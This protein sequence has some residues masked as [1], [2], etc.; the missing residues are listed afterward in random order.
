ME[1][2]ALVDPVGG[3]GGMDYY[4]YGLCYGLHLNEVEVHYFTCNKTKSLIKDCAIKH[5]VFGNIWAKPKF[6]KLILLLNG[7]LQAFRYSR[8]RGINVVHYQFFDLGFYNIIAL[9]LARGFYLKNSVTLHDVDAFRSQNSKLLQKLAFSLSDKIIVHNQF[10]YDQLK[11][12][13]IDESKMALIP[14]GNYLPFVST[15]D[16]NEIGKPLHLLFFGQ[17]KEV[18]GLEILLEA[19]AKVNKNKTKVHLTIAGKPWGVD[20]NYYE[21]LITSLGLNSSTTCY[22]KYIPNDE[23]EGFFKRAD[24]IVLPYKK[25]YQSGVL[26]LAMSYGR[27]VIASNLS[28]FSEIIKDN[29]TGYLFEAQNISSLANKINSIIDNNQSIFEIRN[30]ALSLL[31]KDFDWQDIGRRTKRVYEQTIE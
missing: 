20:K 11:L 25:I 28:A 31:K 17:I 8:K 7:Y 30:N 5:C 16:Y 24:I 12:K 4:D 3:H 18:K 21:D 26:L 13:N 23:V 14:H 19:V 9:L 6:I 15:Q 1:K 29:E 10:S 22:F 2:I 27:V